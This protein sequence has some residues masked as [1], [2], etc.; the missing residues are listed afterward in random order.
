[1]PRRNRRFAARS[2]SRLLDACCDAYCGCQWLLR[3][4]IHGN[5]GI[6]FGDS[7]EVVLWFRLLLD[8]VLLLVHDLLHTT[9]QEEEVM[10]ESLSAQRF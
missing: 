9:C 5:F 6:F 1:M 10:K 7:H 4:G 3:S 8:F 2:S